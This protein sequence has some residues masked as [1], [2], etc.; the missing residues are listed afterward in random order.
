M[1]FDKV[2]DCD[3]YEFMNVQGPLESVEVFNTGAGEFG[4]SDKNRSAVIICKKLN[5]GV[6]MDVMNER[7]NFTCGRW[8]S[9]KERNAGGHAAGE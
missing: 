2:R 6:I 9:L 3:A 4:S 7:E 1:I 8:Y 5:L